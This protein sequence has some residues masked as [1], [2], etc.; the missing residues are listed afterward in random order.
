MGTKYEM[1]INFYNILKGLCI[2]VDAY[3]LVYFVLYTIS[4]YIYILYFI[5]LMIKMVEREMVKMT[6]IIWAAVFVCGCVRVRMIEGM[7]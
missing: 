2:L 3:I 4:I 5:L 7:L 1:I 6:S